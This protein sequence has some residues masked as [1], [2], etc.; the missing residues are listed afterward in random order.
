M[1]IAMSSCTKSPET[2][3][4]IKGHISGLKSDTLWI[5]LQGENYLV[6]DTIITRNGKFEYTSS[7]QN[8]TIVTLSPRAKAILENGSTLDL[9]RYCDM[10]LYC[11]PDDKLKIEGQQHDYTMEWLASGSEINEDFSAV[12]QLQASL[13]EELAKDQVDHLNK[14]YKQAEELRKSTTRQ[15]VAPVRPST[16]RKEVSEKLRLIDEIFIKENPHSQYALKVKIGDRNEDR[17]VSYYQQLPKEVKEGYFGKQMGFKVQGIQL[18][19][20]GTKVPN[21]IQKTIDNKEFILSNL[22]GKY[23]VLDFWGTWC[24]WCIKGVPHMKEYYNKYNDR[25]EYVGI[26]CNE[27]KGKNAVLKVVQKHEMNWIHLMNGVGDQNYATMFAISGYP[28][29]ILIDPEGKIVKKFKGEG[30]DFY[31]LLD[32]LLKVE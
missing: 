6:K 31:D 13:Y 10:V 20:A 1:A 11:K 14:M 17:L 29:K 21:I 28:S 26:A 4:V 23:V 16:K 30:Q 24:G 2:N 12:R 27:S 22:K 8:Y 7:I 9:N 25:L 5:Q 15:M 18:S 32:E 19:K 3:L